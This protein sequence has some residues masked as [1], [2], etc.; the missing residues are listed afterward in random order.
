MVHLTSPGR[1]KDDKWYISKT[2]YPHDIYPPFVRAGAMIMSVNVLRDFYAASNYVKHF[3]FDDVYFGLIA[4]KLNIK[5]VHCNL[6]GVHRIPTYKPKFCEILGLHG[7]NPEQLIEAW[8]AH[9]D[10]TKMTMQE[11]RKSICKHLV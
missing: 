7:Y 2:D 3:V 4:Y 11:T 10:I 1:S 9:R 8:K 6:F 5:P